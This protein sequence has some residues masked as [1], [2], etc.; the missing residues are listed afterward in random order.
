MTLP[1]S[2]PGPGIYAAAVASYG[3][4]MAIRPSVTPCLACLVEDGR[5]AGQEETCD[6]RRGPWP[7][8]NLIASLEVSEALKI[9]SGTRGTR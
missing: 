4:T 5:E 6:I 1:S 2:I 7:I 3:V 9:L 8:V